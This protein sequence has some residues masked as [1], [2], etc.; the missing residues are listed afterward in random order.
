MGGLKGRVTIG[1]LCALVACSGTKTT[2][3]GL[4]TG[5]GSAGT[6]TP[7]LS[8][9]TT[10]KDRAAALVVTN[11]DL[12]SDWL[13]ADPSVTTFGTD[14]TALAKV[15]ETKFKPCGTKDYAPD[16]TTKAQ[17]D[18]FTLLYGSSASLDSADVSSAAALFKSAALAKRDT[19]VNAR[20]RVFSCATRIISNLFRRLGVPNGAITFE[21]HRVPIARY[22]DESTA[23]QLT[24]RL[25]YE[26]QKA[27]FFLRRVTLRKGRA[28]AVINFIDIGVAFPAGLETLVIK[29]VATRLSADGGK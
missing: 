10:D 2:P 21:F 19:E 24:G 3:N 27:S 6:P 18:D 12:G 26:G 7:T 16:L 4:A 25:S 20:P 1:L 14:L 23:V 17:G 9:P 11:D 8:V 29:K 22:A 15:Y 28:I 13:G 5:T